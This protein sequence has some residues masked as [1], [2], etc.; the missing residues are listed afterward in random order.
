VESAVLS[1]KQNGVANVKVVVMCVGGVWKHVS[2]DEPARS[3]S[4]G[5]ARQNRAVSTTCS[6]DI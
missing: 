5:F 6:V 2:M 4:Y 1:K 3:T